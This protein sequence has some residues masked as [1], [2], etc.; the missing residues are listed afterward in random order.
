M[1]SYFPEPCYAFCM[2]RI[3]Q[4]CLLLGA[5]TVPTLAHAD[6]HGMRSPAMVVSGIGLLTV[7]T[8]TVAITTP[9][10]YVFSNPSPAC[11][12][13][14]CAPPTHNTGMIAGLTAGVVAG[15]LAIAAGI[16]LVYLGAKHRHHED[17]AAVW[18]T[19]NGV[20]GRF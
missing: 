18:L 2:R 17:D 16:P 8:V 15:A 19:V 3:L 4:A 11:S 14:G 9:I 12:Q 6:D 20:A 13:W 5:L 10:L 7:G 1:G